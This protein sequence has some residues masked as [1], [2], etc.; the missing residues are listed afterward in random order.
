VR[1]A[2]LEE[3]I[4]RATE[5][6][7][8]GEVIIIGSQAILGTWDADELPERATLS[9]EADVVPVRDDARGLVAQMIDVAIGEWSEFDRAHGFYGQGVSLATAVLPA[10]WEERIV[11]VEPD[12]PGGAA[13]LCL[14]PLDLCAAKLV[15]GEPKDMDFVGALVD[16][17]LIDPI[18]LA[19][20][21]AMLPTTHRAIA[22]KRAGAFTAG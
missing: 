2:D 9:R 12:G 17:A 7:R 13:G 20:R 14:D 1:R 15:R 11:R 21:V 8:Q 22:A 6:S 5:V 18:V 4:R 19:T 3:I 16:A 10:G